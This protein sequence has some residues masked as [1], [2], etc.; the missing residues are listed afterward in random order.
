MN[1]FVTDS[2]PLKSANNLDDKRVNKMILESC[3][4][5]GTALIKHGA[6]ANEL[7]HTKAGKPYRATHHNHPCTIWAGATKS[8]YQWLL[9]HM[10]GLCDEFRQ[11]RHHTHACESN[12]E[13]LQAGIEYIPDGPLQDFQNSSQFKEMRD[14]IE[15][16]R[17]TM[18]M[19]WDHLDKIP[20]V[21]SSP[22][23][24]PTWA[25]P[26]KGKNNK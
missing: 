20:P 12:I 17:L 7:P 24:R 22:A 18:I 3:Q 25:C 4:M 14:I 16:Y 6:P 11:R 2:C 8:N 19:K 15:G 23:S 9:N 26:T 21:W 5:L 1:I 13:V 10:A